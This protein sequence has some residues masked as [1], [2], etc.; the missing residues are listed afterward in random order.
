MK[1]E[2]KESGYFEILDLLHRR[3]NVL[4]GFLFVDD[5]PTTSQ[6]ERTKVRAVLKIAKA[7]ICKRE[8]ERKKMSKKKEIEKQE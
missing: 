8:A 3:H 4:I 7:L 6:M 2:K 1:K 5:V